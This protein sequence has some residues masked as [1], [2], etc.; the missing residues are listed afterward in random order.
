MLVGNKHY[1]LNLDIRR[2]NKR[3]VKSFAIFKFELYNG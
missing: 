3:A 1:W 2:L